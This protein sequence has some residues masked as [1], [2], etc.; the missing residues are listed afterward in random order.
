V[1]REPHQPV[2]FFAWLLLQTHQHPKSASG[3]GQLHEFADCASCRICAGSLANSDK[4]QFLDS[5]S[6]SGT[7]VKVAADNSEIETT[8]FKSP[9]YV[10]GL[11]LKPQ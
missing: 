2:E 3:F 10:V 6:E 5:S 4:E 7:T 9:G 1:L 8:A 11:R